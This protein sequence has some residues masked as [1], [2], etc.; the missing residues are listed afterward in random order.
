MN[1]VAEEDPRV[2]LD[3]FLR[4]FGVEPVAVLDPDWSA[5]LVRQARGDVLRAERDGVLRP[6]SLVFFTS[7]SSGRPRAVHRS[8]ASWSDS[9]DA[10]T[11]LFGVSPTTPVWLPGPMHS[12][13]FLFGAW[14]AASVGARVVL[15]GEDPRAAVIAHAVPAMIPGILARRDAGELPAL[16]TLVVAGDRLPPSYAADVRARGLRLVEYYGAAELSIVGAR[17]GEGPLVPVDGVD[18]EI[19]DGLVWSRS[20]YQAHGYLTPDTGAPLRRGEDGWASVG[21]LGEAVGDGFVVTGRGAEAV[22]VGGHTVVVED[23]EA[24]LRGVPGVQ[25]AAVVG[26]PH[27]RLGHRLVGAV[28]G[29]VTD[30]DLRSALAALPRAARPRRWARLDALPRSAAGKLLR[31]QLLDLVRAEVEGP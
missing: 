10:V 2:A 6:D 22:T 29:P 5:D 24:F 31:A 15:G 7:G 9:L 3:V 4:S 14:H 21:D 1:V 27:R 30:A 17:D 19:R 11:R 12:T 28:V 13:L 20:R 16:S 8:A 25:D 26:V 18:V 23:V